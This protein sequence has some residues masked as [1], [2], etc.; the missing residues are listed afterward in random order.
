M[1]NY[2]VAKTYQEWERETDVYEVN[3]KNY[4]KVRSPSGAVR[5]V[6]AYT[7]AEYRK[8]YNCAPPSDPAG[9]ATE[10]QSNLKDILGFTDGYIWIFKGD[11]DG[12]EYWFESTKECRYHV[13]FGWYI[14]SSD[15]VPFNIPSCITAVKLPWEKVG[16][17]DGT[18]LPKAAITDAI[19]ALIFGEYPSEYQG[20]IGERLALSL[21]LT[22]I[23]ELGETSYG[24]ARIFC[25]EDADKNQYSWTTGVT[26]PWEIGDRIEA[27]AT[28]KEH[29]TIKGAKKTILTRLMEV[30]K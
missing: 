14:V 10:T 8:M 4:I 23:I 21:T 13:F 29:S 2:Y 3:K 1:S 12:A 15:N 18:L 28:V 9:E 26:K 5:Q 6:R 19:N 30:K 27:K 16:K 25:F 22:Q 11:L 24:T 20:S 17:S 7:D